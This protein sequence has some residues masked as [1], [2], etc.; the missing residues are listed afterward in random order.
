MLKRDPMSVLCAYIEEAKAAE[1][2]RLARFDS[3]SCQC[4]ISRHRR[5]RRNQK[6]IISPHFKIASAALMPFLHCLE[7]KC[8][9]M[10]RKSAASLE[11]SG[12]TS[13]EEEGGMAT[14]TFFSLRWPDFLFLFS[15][16]L[17]L[18]VL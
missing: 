16:S 10:E 1:A 15:L 6:N 13:V 7:S 3:R 18:S 12:L 14:R 11:G 17:S 2:P 4:S 9:T 5:R 8:L